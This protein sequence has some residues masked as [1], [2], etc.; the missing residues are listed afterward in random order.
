MI[1]Q[2]QNEASGSIVVPICASDLAK[3]GRSV[4]IDDE[5]CRPPRRLQS[6]RGQALSQVNGQRHMH[7]LEEFA[8]LL[9]FIRGN[10]QKR[11][12]IGRQR[13]SQTLDTR[14]LSNA[15]YAGC[16]PEI[17]EQNFPFEIGEPDWI[18]VQSSDFPGFMCSSCSLRRP[19]T[20][21]A[22]RRGRG[23]LKDHCEGTE[24]RGLSQRV[25]LVVKMLSP[26]VKQSHCQGNSS[27]QA[28]G[29]TFFEFR[30]VNPHPESLRGFQSIEGW[31]L[32]RKTTYNLTCA[33]AANNL[34][35]W[36][37]AIGSNI[38]PKP[39]TNAETDAAVP[40][41]G[42]SVGNITRRAKPEFLATNC[43]PTL[44]LFQT[45]QHPHSPT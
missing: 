31:N 18:P 17:K 12:P 4:P 42:P 28:D 37:S 5:N 30:H 34:R 9:F 35:S 32:L 14:H 15:G 13:I 40:V 44:V 25:Y 10:G 20:G 26:N 45:P 11:D 6:G 3:N 8:H 23:A 7:F 43:H 33:G 39:I 21:K 16:R 19:G 36:L 41:D 27:P 22:T 24:Q 38:N 2:T 1:C 29:E